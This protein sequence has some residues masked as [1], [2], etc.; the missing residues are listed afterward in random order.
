MPSYR[1]T[2]NPP[3]LFPG[4]DI[5]D[6]VASA[7]TWWLV[8]TAHNREKKV[9]WHFLEAG[10][11]YFLPMVERRDEWRRRNLFPLFPGYLFAAPPPGCDIRS[12][13]ESG[14]RQNLFIAEIVHEEWILVKELADIQ[15]GIESGRIKSLDDLEPGQLARVIGGAF[16]GV[17]GTVDRI[18]R[19]RGL[20]FITA[21]GKQVEVAIAEVEAA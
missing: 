19:R 8:S 20:A 12:P 5:A 4:S 7:P 9:A 17:E 21:N 3:S 10:I 2:D 1:V 13:I 15:T 6:L 16:L 14:T 11:P 18:D